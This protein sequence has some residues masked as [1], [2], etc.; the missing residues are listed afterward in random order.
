MFGWEKS[1]QLVL[2][3]ENSVYYFRGYFRKSPHD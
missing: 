3:V 1:V 2:K